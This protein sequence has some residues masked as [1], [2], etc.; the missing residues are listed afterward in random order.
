MYHTLQEHAQRRFNTILTDTVRPIACVARV[1][2]THEASDGI[3]AN[4]I[5]AASDAL[6]G[7]FINIC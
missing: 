2:D 4:A 6:Q 3:H 7:T 1:T 5:G